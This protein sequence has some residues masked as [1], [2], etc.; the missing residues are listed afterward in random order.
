[1]IMRDAIRLNYALDA[2]IGAF[3]AFKGPSQ[4][5]FDVWRLLAT[6]V[7]GTGFR[8][9]ELARILLVDICWALGSNEHSVFVGKAIDGVTGDPDEPF[10]FNWPK[11][12]EASPDQPAFTVSDDVWHFFPKSISD[13][14]QLFETH[15]GA[16]A[17]PDP[18]K[19][20]LCVGKGQ[21]DFEIVVTEPDA[22]IEPLCRS[23]AR[24]FDIGAHRVP[25]ETW[26][27]EF[28]IRY[29]RVVRQ[30]SN[31]SDIWR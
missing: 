5:E 25:L 24:R 14:W 1:M 18:T 10:W 17:T 22:K 2:N 6:M 26:Q 23:F 20:C 31:A 16:S 19:R 4:P 15:P 8:L 7:E 11:L 28:L 29:R 9:Q 13:L 27:R 30:R 12:G 21:D 3:I